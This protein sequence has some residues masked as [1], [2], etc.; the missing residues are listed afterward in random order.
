[1]AK[2]MVI[3][4]EE[5]IQGLLYASAPFHS[6]DF[7]IVYNSVS[8]ERL[9]DKMIELKADIV[10][11]QLRTPIYHAQNFFADL[12]EAN[13]SPLLFAFETISDDEIT[14]FTTTYDDFDLLDKLKYFFSTALEKDYNC[15]FSYIG[16]NS[17]TNSIM[18]SRLKKLEKTEYMNDI[19]R[20]VTKQEL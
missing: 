17:R 12:A 11:F 10:M 3:Y 16:E 15:Y 8:Y 1:M 18:S 4:T 14:Y 20:G 6:D 5:K 19:L 9:I 13:I 2:K 7:E